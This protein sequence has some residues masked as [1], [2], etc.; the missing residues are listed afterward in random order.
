VRYGLG[1]SRGLAQKGYSRGFFFSQNISL[2]ADLAVPVERPLPGLLAL[3]AH[4]D[5]QQPDF[6]QSL[7]IRWQAQNWQAQFGDFPMGRPESPFASPS[8]LLKG[9]KVNWQLSDRLSLSAV[10]S[11]VEG[12]QQSR[13]FRGNTVEEQIT[14]AFHP[15][16]QPWRE[17]PY[18]RN[19]RGLEYFPLGANYVEGFTKVRLAFQADAHMKE[20]LSSY[21]LG[22]LFETIQEDPERELDSSYYLVIFTGEEYFLALRTEFPSLLRDRLLAY[23]EDYNRKK[24]L[25]AEKRKEYPLSE[26]TGYER[27]FLERLSALV[28]LKVD[29]LSFR[30]EE[31]LHGRFY[32]LGRQGIQKE[33]V[34]V[35]VQ[36]EGEFIEIDDPRLADYHYKVYPDVGVIEFDFPQE[37]FED[38]ESAVRVSYAY[39]TSSGTYVL[40]LSVLKGSEKVYLNGEL[41]Q[42]GVDYLIEY[43]TG[44][45]ILFREIGSDDVLRVDYEIARGGLGGFSEYRRSFQGITLHYE[46]TDAL[47]LDLDLLQAYDS[48]MPG[49]SRETLH[50]MPNTHTVL[51][52]SGTFEEEG[53]QGDFHLGFNVNRFPPD[54]NLRAHLPDKIYVIRA[55]RHHGRELI[56]F[57][58]RNGLLVY[59]GRDFSHYGVAEGLAGPVVYDISVAPGRVAF[60]TS[61]GVSLLQLDPGDPLASFARP[62]NWKRLGE[63]E[64]LPSSKAFSVLIREGTLWVGTDRGL[65]R[66][67]LDHLDEPESWKLYRKSDH[68]KMVSDQI[69]EL[70]FARKTLYIGTDRGLM[71]FDPEGE[72]FQAVE[73]LEGLFIN[74]LAT[75]GAVV[76]AATDLGIRALEG[77]HGVGWAVF[78]RAVKAL[79]V[80]G[81]ELWFGTSEGLYGLT[82]GLVPET[83]GREI[84]ALGGSEEA[85][86]A[87]EEATADYE[88]SLFEVGSERVRVHP[89]QETGLSG[90]AEG[91]FIDIPASEHTDYGWLGRITLKKRLG[92]LQLEGVLESIS[93]RFTP[94][95]TLDRRDLLRLSLSA[96]YPLS[97]DLSLSAHHEEGF[98]DLF[99]SPSQTLRDTIGLSFRPSSG[100][101]IDLDYTLERI[102]RDFEHP[103]FDALQRSYGFSAQQALLGKRL[104]LR[105]DYQLDRSEDL[106]RPLYSF[107]QGEL[108]AEAAFRPLEGLRLRLGYRQPLSWRFGHLVGLGRLDWGASWS[109]A[110]SLLSLQADYQGSS[111]LPLGGGRGVL[112]QSAQALL[113][114]PSF[115]MG[116]A[117]LSPQARLSLGLKDLGG[118]NSALEL[119]GEG[120]LKGQI[121]DLEGQISYKRSLL[122][123]E[124]SQ[125]ERL[126]DRLRVSLDYQ[127]LPQLRP[128]LE[129]SGS[130]ETLFHPLFGSKRSGQYQISLE[131]QWQTGGPLQG[132]L[133]LAHQ[134]I[135][136]ERERMISFSLQQS[137]QYPLLPGLTPRLEF[138]AEYLKGRQRGEPTDQLSGELSIS[139]DFT[140]LRDWSATLTGSLL[141]GLDALKPQGSYQ[142]FALTLQFG[143]TFSLF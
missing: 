65:A 26:G 78:G 31:G 141:F 42:P 7:K 107:T 108:S 129:F 38:P 117:S 106:R 101:R 72:T 89:R 43:E 14:F 105:L 103:G 22:F 11:R 104:T 93:P 23:I 86:W 54:D 62:A 60:A 32:A 109:T 112:D 140:L 95:G 80:R 143:R 35:E 47:R 120:T 39:R 115:R 90:W 37:F 53:F 77:D 4:L 73:E 3:V 84:S 66:V 94:I 142:S 122:S 45:L 132:D 139:G 44:F 17:E 41:L 135:E 6:L 18:L 64:G 19:L 137:L 76:Y 133:Y 119:E 49:L 21:G 46:P 67:P 131:L 130:L 40:G 99:H 48:P 5:N 83:R 100:P 114:A 13:T 34:K 87:G 111:Q 96:T 29:S 57:G 36:V 58:H 124:R 27:G 51:G 88:L 2:D 138:Q 81:S 136:G 123:Y 15:P 97:P 25:T 56:L 10:L 12:I 69:F 75:D 92:P 125:L 24:G 71:V 85:L 70:A 61:G 50:T 79:A 82:R 52:L 33:S 63:S 116:E 118:P 110:L 74:D 30:P 128:I 127:G 55:L 91:R 1:D 113:Q 20:L 98:F 102:D 126:E 134:R 59:D 8:R 121:A 9:F 28:A 68:P 16:H